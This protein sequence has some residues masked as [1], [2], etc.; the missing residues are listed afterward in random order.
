MESI[1]KT[2]EQLYTVSRHLKMG[3]QQSSGTTGKLTLSDE[4]LKK[5]E[6]FDLPNTRTVD[7]IIKSFDKFIIGDVNITY[8]R[9]IFNTLSQT[10][11]QSI[12]DYISILRI[13]LKQCS[14]CNSCNDSILRDRIIVGIVNNETRAELLKIRNLS[15]AACIDACKATESAL[16]F[17]TNI[18]N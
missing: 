12:E 16:L 14:Y 13:Q 8:E 9:Y 17:N 1:Q 10:S 4:A 7:D 2:M 15:L 5:Y 6:G 3:E 11:S 18:N